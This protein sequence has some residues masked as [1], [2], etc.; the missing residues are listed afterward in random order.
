[1]TIA[2]IILAATLWLYMGSKVVGQVWAYKRTTWGEDV[3]LGRKNQFRCAIFWPVSYYYLMSNR[4][5]DKIVKI[6]RDEQERQKK[7]KEKIKEE[8]KLLKKEG[9]ILSENSEGI[10]NIT[11]R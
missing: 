9:L 3:N 4:E 10:P 6:Y 1:M 11:R 5:E 2:I 8:E 7:L